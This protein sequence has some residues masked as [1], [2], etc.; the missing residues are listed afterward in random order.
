MFVRLH[1]YCEHHTAYWLPAVTVLLPPVPPV[2]FLPPLLREEVD[3]EV[4]TASLST[5][6]SAMKLAQ[7]ASAKKM[8]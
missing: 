4:L 3:D 8:D 5:A 7:A 6:V 2:G 1:T